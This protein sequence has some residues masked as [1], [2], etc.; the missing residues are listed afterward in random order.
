MSGNLQ[1]EVALVTGASRGIGAAIAQRLAQAGATVIGT[2]T[3]A[4]GAEAIGAALAA[5][6]GHGRVLDV[7][8]G[9]AVTAALDA[10]ESA[11]GPLRVLVNNAGINK[12]T[13][14]DK[15][16]DDDWDQILATNLKGPFVCSQLALPRLAAA[17]GGSI[18]HIGSVSGQYGGPRTAHYAASKAG[19]IGFTKSLAREV[20]RRGIT[21][22][23]IAPGFIATEMTQ[24]IP[25]EALKALRKQIPLRRLGKASEVARTTAFLIGDD[26]RYMTG[27][28]LVLDGGLTV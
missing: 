1:G 10:T 2:A 9:A 12:P 22:N 15:V 18:V 8:D 19:L 14:F 11:F 17:G 6:G 20:A 27:Q 24:A 23:A 5:Q 26:S 16:T 25:P 7:T 21:V 13:D 3:S 28:I 4:A